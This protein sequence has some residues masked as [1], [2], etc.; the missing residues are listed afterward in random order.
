MLGHLALFDGPARGASHPGTE[1]QRE[2][3]EENLSLFM[4]AVVAR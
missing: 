3:P 1:L 2:G 4:V